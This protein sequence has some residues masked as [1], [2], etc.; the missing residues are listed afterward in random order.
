LAAI[1]S[2]CVNLKLTEVVVEAKTSVL[3]VTVIPSKTTLLPNSTL[4]ILF[5]P[6]KIFSIVRFPHLIAISYPSIK[7]SHP[8]YFVTGSVAKIAIF[9]PSVLSKVG[10]VVTKSIPPKNL[11]AWK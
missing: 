11:V 9:T 3:G 6:L 1:G 8:V 5:T 7:Y 10:A 2:F 4:F